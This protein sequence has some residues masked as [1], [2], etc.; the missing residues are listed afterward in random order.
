MENFEGN[1]DK[2][3]EKSV[4]ML[5]LDTPRMVILGSVVLGLIV[6]AFLFGMNFIKDDSGAAAAQTASSDMLT[7]ESSGLSAFNQNIPAPPHSGTEVDSDSP[8]PA[9]SDAV[10]SGTAE[11]KAADDKQLADS[12]AAKTEKSDDLK[13]ADAKPVK[14]AK[15]VLTEDNLKE[16]IPPAGAKKLA[17]TKKKSSAVHR[18]SAKKKKIASRRH[19]KHRSTRKKS[20]AVHKK[21][22]R[23]VP[24][25]HNETGYRNTRSG[26]AIQ[27]V[28][29][30]SRSKAVHEM[31]KLR[32]M[33]YSAYM[34]PT[35]VEGRRFFRV[36]IGPLSSKSKALSLLREVQ[37]ID[38]YSGSYMVKE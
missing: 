4:Y 28:S 12:S 33:H 8:L 15:D 23:V 30:D 20:V 34:D 37:G 14:E 27:V 25:V 32:K 18:N 9:D 21:R 16:I 36:R 19:V 2:V 26:F 24:V 5:H 29:Y 7:P 17:E 31:D 38:R 10:N 11:E 22:S 3:R 6:V 35:S 13:T 1:Q